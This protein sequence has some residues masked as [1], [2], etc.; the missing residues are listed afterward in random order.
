MKQI[1]WLIDFVTSLGDMLKGIL[2]LFVTA[3]SGLIS[4][5]QMLPSLISD[6]STAVGLLPTVLVTFFG[7]SLTVTIIY[8]ILG[9][10][11]GG[12]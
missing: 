5:V 9:R 11:K 7:I 8:L 2:N 4:L 10:G 1:Q 12:E 3:F 6:M